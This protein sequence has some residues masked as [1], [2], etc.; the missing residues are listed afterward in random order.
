MVQRINE[1]D[2]EEVLF[3]KNC[4]SLKIREFEGRDY[5]DKCGYLEIESANI[6]EW[7]EEYAKAYGEDAVVKNN[8]LKEFL[9]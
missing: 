4:L 2:D 8:Y 7:S 6:K 1:F 5:C 9:Q 3:C